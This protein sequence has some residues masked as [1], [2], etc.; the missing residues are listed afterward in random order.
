MA[1]GTPW[2]TDSFNGMPYRFLGNSGLR[3]SNVGL[4]TWKFGFPETGDGARV[5]RENGL[6]MLDAALESGVTFWDTANRYNNASGN[7]ERIIGEWFQNNPD[8]RRNIVLA[9]KVFGGM[10]GLTPNH[11]RLSRANILDSVF[12]S[13]ERLKLD[14]IDLLY[15]HAYDPVIPVEESLCAVEDLIRKDLVNRVK[16]EILAGIY[17]TPE[18]IE[19]TIDRLLEE[20]NDNWL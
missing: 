4:G 9:T 17:E 8:Q 14:Y 15:F 13:L 20:F 7:S 5:D 1:N 2:T 16:M 6:E 10:D 18:R 3:V 19:G 11:S 12:A